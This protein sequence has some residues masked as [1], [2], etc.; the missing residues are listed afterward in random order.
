MD[1]FFH[2]ISIYKLKFQNM[3]RKLFLLCAMALVITGAMLWSC[4]KEE[5]LNPEDGLL[6]K[7]GKVEATDAELPAF[8]LSSDPVCID[9]EVTVRFYVGQV[10]NCG[11][12]R[13]DML[14][15]SGVSNDEWTIK[16]LDDVPPVEGW[17]SYTL[18]PDELGNYKFRATS[19]EV[20]NKGDKCGV[21]I[22]GFEI[23]SNLL[24]I[25][26]DCEYEMKGKLECETDGYNRKATFSFKS[27]VDGWAKIQGGISS[28][29]INITT[30]STTNENSNAGVRAWEGDITACVPV[31]IEV[32][33][34]YE[35]Y[36][37]KGERIIEDENVIGDWTVE[38]YDKEGGELIK[39]MKVDEMF[40]GDIL[41]G[42]DPYELD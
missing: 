29:A 31:T 22:S 21:S 17:V 16:V 3:K 15:P 27:E 5:L 23:S 7:K 34:E 13:L 19:S 28:G 40:C 37:K 25:D 9:D 30:L 8:D 26:C 42:Y 4:Q 33:W 38:L 35:K 39:V 14:K 41:E 6:L 1:V 36:N 2:S 11:K 20:N 18:T 10:V 12:V 32:L 24:V